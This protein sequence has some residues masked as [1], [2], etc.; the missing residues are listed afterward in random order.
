MNLAQ[1]LSKNHSVDEVI[2]I[3]LEKL[4][5]VDFSIS[6][7]RPQT[8]FEDQCLLFRAWQECS[9]DEWETLVND[10]VVPQ[11]KWSLMYV[12][13]QTRLNCYYKIKQDTQEWLDV[14]KP[15]VV[16][17]FFNPFD[18]SDET[19]HFIFWN[20]S[21]AS[22]SICS[23]MAGYND[24]MP[25]DKLIDKLLHPEDLTNNENII[26]GKLHEPDARFQYESRVLKL[27]R[28]RARI[29]VGGLYID[30]ND[31]WAG[32][33]DD[34][35]VYEILDD[36]ANESKDID[37]YINLLLTN[38]IDE[39]RFLTHVHFL[40]AMEAKCPGAGKIEKLYKVI[41]MAY[42]WQMQMIMRIRTLPFIDFDVWNPWSCYIQRRIN[43]PKKAEQL[44][45]DMRQF[46]FG[47]YLKAAL[48]D[49]I[50]A[51]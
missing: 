19:P 27:I 36:D 8:K 21:R 20:M 35:I 17:L 39:E 50:G 4:L 40:W 49:G 7:P 31:P 28:P 43:E 29:F 41:P 2:K 22:A 33:S 45:N 37:Y 38:E 42:E 1:K 12:K 11:V 23:D 18:Q 26:H 15:T 34:G 48:L 5:A 47:P 16:F 32:V 44:M 9:S 30:K 10:L 24:W 14:R 46:W 3:H 6:S 25:F 13:E 51:Y